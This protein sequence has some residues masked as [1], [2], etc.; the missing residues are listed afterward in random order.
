MTKNQLDEI[1]D[2]KL[3]T[4]HIFYIYTLP[5]IKIWYDFKK[6]RTDQICANNNYTGKFKK[7]IGI[8]DSILNLEKIDKYYYWE[9][10][11]VYQFK[12]VKGISFNVPDE[13]LEIDKKEQT[14][15]YICIYRD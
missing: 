10:E 6:K 1:D 4:L 14:I 12:S 15:E 3:D 9:D 7:I 2:A 8:N 5:N 11:E 13:Q